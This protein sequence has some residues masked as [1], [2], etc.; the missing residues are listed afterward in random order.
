MDE[1]NLTLEYTDNDGLSRGFQRPD[2]QSIIDSGVSGVGA[3]AP[4]DDA[5]FAQTWGRPQ[6]EG[7]RFFLNSGFELSSS[8]ELYVRFSLADTDGRYRFFY[9]HP[10]SR[11]TPARSPAPA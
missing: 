2:A 11:P 8:S 10:G 6:T 3:D 4:F 9:R 5:P 7:V 1:I